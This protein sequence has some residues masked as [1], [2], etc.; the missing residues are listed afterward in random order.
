MGELSLGESSAHSLGIAFSFS[1]S[2]EGRTMS[3]VIM[4]GCDLHDHSM[5]IRFAVGQGKPKEDRFSNDLL[6]RHLLVERMQQLAQEHGADRV[7][8][9]YEASGQGYGLS[10]CLHHEG[11]E[12]YV[13]SPN[14]LPKTPKSAKQK[15]DSKDAQML[16]EQLRGFVLAGNPLP[17]VWTPPQR[18]RDDRELVRARVDASDDTTRI[19]LQILSM[20]KRY[21]ILKPCWYTTR[22]SKRFV[23]WLRDTAAEMDPVVAP[24]LGSLIDRHELFQAEQN[25][26]DKA[27][28]ALSQTDRYRDACKELRLLPGV[29]LLTAMTFLTEMGDLERFHNR[30]EVAAYLGLCP[31]SFETGKADDRKGRIT[32]QGPSRLRKL[33]CQAAW[34]SLRDSEDAANTYLRI[35]G[36]KRN[37][38]KKAL[39]AIMRRLA[40]EMWHCARAIGT[41]EELRGRGGPH[42]G[43]TPPARTP[44]AA[45]GEHFQESGNQSIG[46]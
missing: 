39:V 5:L 33:L 38:T 14:R 25:K 7:V 43:E 17:V 3:K 13:L 4:I 26:F 9:A 35:R 36:G 31:A 16:L 42:E 23:K 11:I 32:R 22:W 21:E 12:C 46:T 34:V 10:D 15:T 45:Y 18:L 41:A 6:G 44:A 19:K 29:G 8:F 2:N 28:K 20:L 37:R 27:I 1:F 24:V 30:R 40:I